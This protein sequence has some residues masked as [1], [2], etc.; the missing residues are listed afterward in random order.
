[1]QACKAPHPVQPFALAIR[2]LCFP[3]LCFPLKIVPAR[4]SELLSFITPQ[5]PVAHVV[6]AASDLS[7]SVPYSDFPSASPQLPA[8]RLL[9][10][11]SC[12]LQV[13]WD[14]DLSNH[15]PSASTSHARKQ[16][17]CTD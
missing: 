15:L 13:K 17:Y 5:Q 6:I 2:N 8:C 4:S 9:Q 11:R 10:H 14:R 16:E 12:L 3:L 1:M 7:L